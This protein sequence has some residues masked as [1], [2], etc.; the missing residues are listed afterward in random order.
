MTTRLDAHFIAYGP[1]RY[2]GIAL[3]AGAGGRLR[4]YWRSPTGWLAGCAV[5]AC[6]LAWPAAAQ[7][8]CNSGDIA[9]TDL[10]SSAN[11][12]ALAPSPDSTA[13]G[14]G[15]ST[16]LGGTAFGQGGLALGL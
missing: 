10:L 2:A 3:D 6:V 12:R 4:K 11:C 5:A 14:A 7:A 16:G 1:R 13:V 8:G 9:N 15:A